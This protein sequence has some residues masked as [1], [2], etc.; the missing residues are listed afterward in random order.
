MNTIKFTLESKPSNSKGWGRYAVAQGE[1][2][3]IE[4]NTGNQ[5]VSSNKEGLAEAGSE[6]E[7]TAQVMLREGK[8][9]RAAENVYMEKTMLIVEDGATAEISFRPGSQGVT[10][11]VE[12][13]R[14]A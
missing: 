11:K 1:K 8:G 6:I 5:W 3:I 7:I 9:F 14:R 4:S 10:I 13:A 12:G 2:K